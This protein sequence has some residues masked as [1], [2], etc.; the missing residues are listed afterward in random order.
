MRKFQKGNVQFS[1]LSFL[2]TLHPKSFETKSENIAH[3]SCF[4]KKS[5]EHLL[6]RE[7]SDKPRE[8]LSRNLDLRRSMTAL[9]ITYTLSV[10]L[11][12]KVAHSVKKDEVMSRNHLLGCMALRGDSEVK[13]YW[14]ARHLLRGH[15]H[16]SL[17]CVCF[18]A[19]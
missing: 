11:K 9:R 2:Q 12:V 17:L 1:L 8:K 10:F 7:I 15:W 3:F 19:R 14:S 6:V 13:R 18:L 16:L 4:C 5:E